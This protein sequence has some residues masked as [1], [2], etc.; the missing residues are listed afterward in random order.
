MRAEY[1]LKA[2]KKN[3][4]ADREKGDPVVRESIPLLKS[5]SVS[6]S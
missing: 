5:V 3:G 6:L 2:K 1:F 4:Q